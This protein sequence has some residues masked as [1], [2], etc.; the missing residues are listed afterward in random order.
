MFSKIKIYVVVLLTSLFLAVPALAATFKLSPS[1]GAM[2]KNCNKVIDVLM[3]IDAG[4]ASNAA[5]I[6]IDHNFSGAGE[7]VSIAGAGLFAS[8]GFPTPLPAGRI[9]LY[10]YTNDI[11][12]TDKRFARITARSGNVGAVKNLV[13]YFNNLDSITSKIADLESNNILT[14]VISGSYLVEDGW[15]ESNPPYLS[16]M[17]PPAN[18]PNHPLDQDIFFKIKDDRTGDSGV[19]ISTLSITLKQGGVAIPFALTTTRVNPADDKAYNVII[20]PD[21]QLLHG[22]LIEVGVTVQ[23]FAGNT[24][25]QNYSFNGLTCEQL[26]CFAY[27]PTCTTTPPTTTEYV[28]V[29]TTEYL[30]ACT[31]DCVVTTTVFGTTTEFAVSYTH[32]T[33]PTIYS[34]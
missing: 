32:L 3:D 21:N 13:I 5:Q 9:G 4:K 8:Y 12:G 23:D 2:I 30:Y 19:K 18:K 10:G 25:I 17:N 1:S 29:T 34:V 28:Y 24:L 31:P 16:D 15:C 33:L 14:T 7:S 22:E 6:Y 26:G 20:N 11:T 27:P